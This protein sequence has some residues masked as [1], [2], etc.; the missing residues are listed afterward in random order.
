MTKNADVYNFEISKFLK[1]SS[2]NAFRFKI[3]FQG[4]ILNTPNE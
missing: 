1:L 3:A 2:K 4:K